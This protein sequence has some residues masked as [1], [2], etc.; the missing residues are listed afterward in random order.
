MAHRGNRSF[1]RQKAPIEKGRFADTWMRCEIMRL[2]VSAA[3]EQAKLNNP[4][5]L[6]WYNMPK[7]CFRFE[8]NGARNLYYANQSNRGGKLV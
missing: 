5:R 3:G 7:K 4:G 1:Y 8:T 2:F 6:F